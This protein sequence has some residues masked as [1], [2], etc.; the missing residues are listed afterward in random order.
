MDAN[1]IIVSQ[2]INA[3]AAQIWQ[4]LTDKNEMLTWYFDIPDFELKEGA[5]FNFYETGGSKNFHHRCEILQIIPNETFQHTWT[6]PSHSQGS[7]VITWHLQPTA[8]GTLVTLTHEGVENFTD[9]GPNFDRENY[10]AGW[11]SIVQ[12]SL[13]NYVHGAIKLK[14]ECI[15]DA[16]PQKVWDLMWEDGVYRRW[17]ASFHDGSYY[18][19]TLQYGGRIHFLTPEGDG[20]YSEII[21]FVPHS[22]IVFKHIGEIRENIEMPLDEA[23]EKWTGFL[24]QYTYKEKNG[25]TLLMVELDTDP[26]YKDHLSHSFETALIELKEI[27]E[28]A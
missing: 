20:M 14:F 5:V 7:S 28:S 4:A 12:S 15:I 27:I 26:K 10:L 2:L 25:A 23:S 16:P 1:P 3:P 19:G 22:I 18:K 13:K 8:K 17:T 21:Y 24:E 9:G 6:H 11:Q